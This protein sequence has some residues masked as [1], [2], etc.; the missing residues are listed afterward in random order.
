VAGRKP[1]EVVDKEVGVRK[2]AGRKWDTDARQSIA[3]LMDDTR[4]S[5]SS[6]FN[7]RDEARQEQTA[8]LQRQYQVAVALQQAS[9]D[10]VLMEL[11][12][13]ALDTESSGRPQQGHALQ[14]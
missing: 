8:D 5:L 3:Q 14:S 1:K 10:E 2:A 13:A 11:A 12:M 6:S 9:R 7:L 4:L